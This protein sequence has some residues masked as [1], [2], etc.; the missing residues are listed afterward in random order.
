MPGLDGFAFLAELSSR[1]IISPV[2]MTTGYSTL[3]NAVRSLTCGAIDFLAKPFT[4]DEL[5]AVI[6]RG[7]KYETL[8]M[9]V[10]LPNGLAPQF[11]SF[12][13]CPARYYRLGYVSWAYLE[14]EGTALV[15]ITDLF[16][17]T[18]DEVRAIDVRAVETEVYQG[19]SFA[20]IVSTDG[21]THGV[22]GPLSGR[23]VEINTAAVNAPVTLEKDPYFSGWLYRVLPC[24]LSNELK[25]LISCSSDRL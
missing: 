8:Q 13:P 23:I 21:L 24:A 10:C 17:K 7:L 18:L 16:F 19:S 5:L 2:I 3:E 9:Q 20:S 14:H 22:L 25:H 11:L 15:G 12:V 1:K 4:A 6:R